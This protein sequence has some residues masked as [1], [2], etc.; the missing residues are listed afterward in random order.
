[1]GYREHYAEVKKAKTGRKLSAKYIEW[2]EKGQQI[3]G[4]LLSRNP[5]D[6]SMGSGTY[7]QYLW[8]TDDGLV[9]CALGKAT[10]GEAGALMM[11]GGVY[12]IIYEGQENLKGGR[13]LNKFEIIELEASE[14]TPVGGSGDIPF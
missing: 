9:K 14:E 4:R 1:M 12:S 8:D 7:F 2:T 3:V 10:D 13:K 11:R 5:V 6:S